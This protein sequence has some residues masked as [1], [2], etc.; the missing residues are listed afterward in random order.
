[1]PLISNVRPTLHSATGDRRHQICGPGGVDTSYQATLPDDGDAFLGNSLIILG[2]PASDVV[3]RVYLAISD[4]AGTPSYP[5]KIGEFL[6]DDTAAGVHLFST[7]DSDTF[8]ASTALSSFPDLRAGFGI[9][10][11]GT[12]AIIGGTIGDLVFVNRLGDTDKF[13]FSKM[14]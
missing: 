11:A 9:N 1:M 6:I 5:T 14:F 2:R 7:S 8:A 12:Q 4:T 13:I 3:I 10:D